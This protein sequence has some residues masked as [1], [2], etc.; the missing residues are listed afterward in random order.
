MILGD[1]S[2]SD[3]VGAVDD[4][5]IGLGYILNSEVEERMRLFGRG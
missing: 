3:L 4:V 2:Y 5:G 1:V